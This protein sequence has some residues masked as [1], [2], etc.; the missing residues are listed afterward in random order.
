MNNILYPLSRHP[1]LNLQPKDA[2]HHQEPPCRAWGLFSPKSYKN[3]GWAATC[4]S[5]TKRGQGGESSTSWY[6]QPE[7]REPDSTV[8]LNVGGKRFEVTSTK[9]HLPLTMTSWPHDHPVKVLWHTLGQFP[10]SRLGRLH[11]CPRSSKNDDYSR[12]RILFQD[13]FNVPQANC[14]VGDLW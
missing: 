9:G 7:Q 6:L 10:Q 12:W 13:D 11:D 2:F 3:A 8:F 4:K 14:H 1:K 5:T